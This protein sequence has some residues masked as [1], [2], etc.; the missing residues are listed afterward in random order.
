MTTLTTT[1]NLLPFPS[2]V[3]PVPF[4]VRSGPAWPQK[5]T[6]I[7]LTLLGD[8]DVNVGVSVAIAC[9]IFDI[10]IQHFCCHFVVGAFAFAFVSASEYFL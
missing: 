3:P 1:N 4:P 8:G 2:L 7:P 10:F 6:A 9:H 5:T